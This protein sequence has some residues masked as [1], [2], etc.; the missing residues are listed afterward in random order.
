M[1]EW[2][3]LIYQG[4]RRV[5]NMW[6]LSLDKKAFALYLWWE[7][8]YQNDHFAIYLAKHAKFQT[9]QLELLFCIN[10]QRLCTSFF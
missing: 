5:Y 6:A 9:L 10:S 8:Q 7:Y 1:D 4:R 3:L 2:D